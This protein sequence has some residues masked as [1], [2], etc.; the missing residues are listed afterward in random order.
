MIDIAPL[1]YVSDSHIAGKGLF[2]EVPFLSGEMVLDYRPLF[3][4]FYKIR[5]TELNEYQI[6][7][8]WYVPINEEY[9]STCDI[10][11]KFIYFN[12]SR[13]PNCEWKINEGLILASRYIPSNQE[14]TIDYRVEYRP[15]RQSFL[16]WI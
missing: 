14:L 10:Q 9:C 7:H 12:H 1:T 8:N 16:D 5:W 11:S 13:N 2:S 15:N 4:E 3:N 6:S